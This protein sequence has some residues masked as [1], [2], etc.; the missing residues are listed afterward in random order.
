MT[1]LLLI[2]HA[3][4][5]TTGARLG[6][7]T[8]TGLDERGRAQ[9]QAAARRLADLPL[10]A[11]YG[12]PLARS[13]QTAELLAAPHGLAVQP[14]EGLVEVE[15]GRWTDRPLK[16]LAR[17]K[18]W[19]VVQA[20]PSLARF[21]DGE[22][23]RQA[24]LRAVDAVEELVAR[25]P[26]DVIAAVTHADV[27]KAVVAFYVGLPLDL[28]QR[29]Q[30]GPASVTVL[31]LSAGGQPVLLRFN[32]DGPL[33]ADGLR[34]PRRRPAGKSAGRTGSSAGASRKA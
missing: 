30:V 8:E 3:T 6:G 27:I 14:L 11:V 20:R 22:S 34:P 18:L 17:T 7:R 33:T 31:R 5:A 32:D 15:Y 12:S 1:T 13:R 19:P 29:L 24:Q 10:K 23:I 4:T 21:P 2:R 26:R 28:F 25:H 9:A 16:P